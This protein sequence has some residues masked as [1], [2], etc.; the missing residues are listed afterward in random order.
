MRR[1][2]GESVMG[3][4]TVHV[5]GGCSTVGVWVLLVIAIMG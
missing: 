3:E 2:V 4:K 1:V 5:S